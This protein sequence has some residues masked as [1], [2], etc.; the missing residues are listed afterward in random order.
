MTKTSC[1]GIEFGP[2]RPLIRPFGAPS[3][4]GGEGKITLHPPGQAGEDEGRKI[5]LDIIPMIGDMHSV[6]SPRGSGHDGDL[7][8]RK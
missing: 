3:P 4:S 8:G 5:L 1:E 2:E 6:S 7:G